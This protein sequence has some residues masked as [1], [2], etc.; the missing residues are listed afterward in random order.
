MRTQ[1]HKLKLSLNQVLSI[2][3]S[4]CKPCQWHCRDVSFNGSSLN[5]LRKKISFII[6]N[7]LFH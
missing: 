1:F 7:K 6:E 2:V 3:H 5:N 4:N